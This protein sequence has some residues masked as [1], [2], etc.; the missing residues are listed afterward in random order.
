MPKK[1]TVTFNSMLSISDV[2]CMEFVAAHE[3]CHFLHPD[4]SKAF[5][6]CLSSVM[7]D[8]KDRKKRLS[9]FSGWL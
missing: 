1:S 6:A 8:W 4:H 7:P 3:L 9:A 5:Y 2:E